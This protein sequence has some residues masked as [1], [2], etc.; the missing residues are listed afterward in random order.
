MPYL[1]GK[2]EASKHERNCINPVAKRLYISDYDIEGKQRFVSWGMTCTTCGVIVKENYE[3][4]LTPEQFK[5]VKRD[6]KF[7]VSKYPKLMEEA[8]GHP[9]QKSLKMPQKRR[10]VKK[11]EIPQRKKL[12]SE[13]MSR[14]ETGL[15]TRIGR[16]KQFYEL[17]GLHW[18]D[19]NIAWD[20]ELVAQ[21]LNVVPRPTIKELSEVFQPSWSKVN[22]ESQKW[23]RYRRYVDDPEKQGWLKSDREKYK[24]LL[25]SEALKRQEMMRDIIKSRAAQSQKK[26]RVN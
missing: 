1:D 16:L 17:M 11:L 2:I 19:L 26:R 5:R 9:W 7:E 13:R 3:L 8:S 25:E 21:F 18:G 23:R 14:R 24:E 12:G 6:K 10:V 20:D 4:N 15:R 22:V